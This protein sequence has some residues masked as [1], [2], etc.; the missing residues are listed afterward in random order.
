MPVSCQKSPLKRYVPHDTSSWVV[1]T[2]TLSGVPTG[3][4][5][6]VLWSMRVGMSFEA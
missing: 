4:V 3:T 2:Y 6:P 1:S 5:L